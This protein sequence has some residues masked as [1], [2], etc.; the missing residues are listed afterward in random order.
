MIQEFLNG[1]EPSRPI[2]PF[3]G[4]RVLLKCALFAALV[5]KT[6]AVAMSNG[7]RVSDDV[8]SARRRRDYDASCTMRR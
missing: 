5:R 4:A 6:L 2:N 8:G 7:E 1:K 3:L